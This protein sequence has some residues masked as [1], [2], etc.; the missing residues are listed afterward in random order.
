MVLKK[1]HYNTI[2]KYINILCPNKRKPKYSNEYYL[3]NIISMLTKFTQIHGEL[4]L[5]Q[6]IIKMVLLK[7]NLKKQLKMIITIKRLILNIF[8]GQKL[9]YMKKLI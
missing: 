1:E 3:K 9:A 7:V 2:L 8:Y 6:L 4:S 5:N